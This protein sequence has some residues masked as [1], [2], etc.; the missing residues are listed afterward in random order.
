MSESTTATSPRAPVA[1]A[2]PAPR[3]RGSRRRTL[4]ILASIS[5][6]WKVLVFTLGAALPHWLLTDGVAELPAPHREYG[7]ASLATARALYNTPVERLGG[8]VQRVRVVS[9]DS[10]PAA[11]DADPV[12]APCL[13][14]ARV[15]AYTYF[16]IP[17]SEVRTRCGRGVIEYRVFRPK[18][19][20]E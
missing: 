9:V 4:L 18:T 15:R 5:V 11:G 14:G 7:I 20:A 16:A 3:R 6:G 10:V 13:L 17:Y 1:E 2:A 8:V 12:S 19:R